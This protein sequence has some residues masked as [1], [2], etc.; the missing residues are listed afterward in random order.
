MLTPRQPTPFSVALSGG[1]VLRG[2]TSGHVEKDFGLDISIVDVFSNATIRTLL[3]H[4]DS[5]RGAEP[6]LFADG[7]R[8][9]LARGYFAQRS[10]ARPKTRSD[11]K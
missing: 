1:G 4:L 3:A 8:A 7:E 9:T 6:G 5:Q 11:F 10:R 2:E